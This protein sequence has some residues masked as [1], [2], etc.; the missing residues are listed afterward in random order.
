MQV[1]VNCI[2][3]HDDPVTTQGPTY[4][5]GDCCHVMHVLERAKSFLWIMKFKT[6]FGSRARMK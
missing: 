5:G 3:G 1:G 2:H 4:L 6:D